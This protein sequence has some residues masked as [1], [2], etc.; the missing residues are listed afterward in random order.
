MRRR[1]RDG[2]AGIDGYAEDYAY[3]IFGLLELF[4]AGGD[5]QWLSWALR[6]QRRMDEMFWDKDNGG[7]FNTTGDDRS[8][9]LRLKEDY[10]GA[11]PAPSS[12]S[13][14]NLLTLAHLT[15][16]PALAGRIEKTLKMFGSRLG[17]L[18]RAVPMMLAGLSTYHAARSQIVIVGAP[19]ASDELL[20][21]V[22]TK[23]L[24]F[25]VVIPVDPGPAHAELAKALPFVGPMEMRG[26]PT[27]YVCRNFTCAAPVT[28]PADL[29]EQLK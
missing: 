19:P 26:A 24:P 17:Q 13:V 4:Q 28:D 16:D 1:Y 23:Y 8:V 6:L 3:V 27:A 12:I 18:G 5:P 10:D 29:R 7:W 11:E 20:Q 21:E 14:L 25:A 22:A 2:E 15:D 9:I